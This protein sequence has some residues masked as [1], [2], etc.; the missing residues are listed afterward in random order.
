MGCEYCSEFIHAVTDGSIRSSVRA[1]VAPVYNALEPIGV[2][3]GEV[4]ANGHNAAV[5]VPAGGGGT[6]VVVVVVVDV[7]VVVEGAPTVNVADCE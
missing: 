6:V 5:R 7:D 3:H 2:F 1:S 4:E